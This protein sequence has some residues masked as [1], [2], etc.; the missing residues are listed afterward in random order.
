MSEFTRTQQKSS[1]FSQFVKKNED[2]LSNVLKGAGTPLTNQ[3]RVPFDQPQK[4]RRNDP[5]F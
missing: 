4:E 2:P 5:R 3:D 1:E